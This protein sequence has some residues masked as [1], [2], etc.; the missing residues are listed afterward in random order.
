MVQE[1][2]QTGI[3]TSVVSCY[4]VSH[5]A[6]EMD[7]F[8]CTQ[9]KTA[10]DEIPPNCDVYILSE[11]FRPQVS[12]DFEVKKV[13]F[14]KIELSAKMILFHNETALQINW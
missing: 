2:T 4:G 10:K 7:A 11:P 5:H 12:E 1:S 14:Y 8:F 6:K 13:Q 9:Y 3:H